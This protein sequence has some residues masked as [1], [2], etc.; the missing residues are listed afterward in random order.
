VVSPRRRDAQRSVLLSGD[1]LTREQISGVTA[2]LGEQARNALG[3]L[4]AA[5]RATFEL[6]Y[7][8]QAFELTVEA[9]LA[10][11]PNELR[12]A[13]ESEHDERYGYSDPEQELQLVTVRVSALMPGASVQLRGDQIMPPGRERRPATLDGAQIELDVV[14]GAPEAGAEIDGPSVVELAESTLLIPPGWSGAVDPTGT[15]RLT[16]A[17]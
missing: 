16:R 17:R 10:P 11:D 4:D 12:V 9:P 5:L 7:R 1:Q 15:I 3:E 8:G 13:F 6:R 2:D 14:R